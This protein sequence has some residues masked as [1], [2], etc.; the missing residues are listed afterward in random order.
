MLN[1]N[2]TVTNAALNVGYESLSQFMRDYKK[3]FG[4]APKEDVL[5][6]RRKRKRQK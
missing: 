3:V 1:E 5:A 4:V 2:V 6:L